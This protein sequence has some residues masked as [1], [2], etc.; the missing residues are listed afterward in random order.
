MIRL[1]L[2]GTVGGFAEVLGL[3]L[4]VPL[5]AVGVADEAADGDLLEAAGAVPRPLV[6]GVEDIRP[7]R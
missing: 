3:L 7:R 1:P 4:L 5:E 2:L 6:V